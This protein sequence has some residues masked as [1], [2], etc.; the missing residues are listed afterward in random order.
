MSDSPPDAPSP[1]ALGAIEWCDLTVPDA[2]A[3]RPFYEQVVGWQVSEHS[4]GDYADF[5]LS[6]EDGAVAGLCHARGSNANLPAQWLLYVRVADVDA[7]ARRCEELGGKVLDGPRPM[8]GLRF[9][10]IQDPQGACLAL[11]ADE[12]A[13]DS[14]KD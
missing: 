3:L 7:S 6:G 8:G 2:A 13:S 10:A 5:V 14:R 12:R 11:I 1:P 4:M 9:C